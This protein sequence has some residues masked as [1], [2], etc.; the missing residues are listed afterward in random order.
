MKTEYVARLSVQ[1][2]DM[3][4]PDR[5]WHGIG[6]TSQWLDR[7]VSSIYTGTTAHET[8]V[9]CVTLW[10]PK[11]GNSQLCPCGQVRWKRS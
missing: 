3:A 9:E 2:G 5:L 1:G 11:R 10:P 6:G 4:E 7:A 8:P